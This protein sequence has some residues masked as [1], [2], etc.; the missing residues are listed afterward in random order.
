MTDE[1]PPAASEATASAPPKRRSRRARY[2]AMGCAGAIALLIAVVVLFSI[3]AAQIG[4][5]D[6]AAQPDLL[7]QSGTCLLSGVRLESVSEQS[8]GPNAL[9]PGSCPTPSAPARRSGS[10]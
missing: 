5:D 3:R 8:G 4:D 9:Q 6:E 2:T 1:T 7:I 10:T